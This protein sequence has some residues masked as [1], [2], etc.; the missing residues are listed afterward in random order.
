MTSRVYGIALASHKRRGVLDRPPARTM[1]AECG[2]PPL[3]HAVRQAAAFSRHD[4]VAGGTTRPLRFRMHSRNEFLR[5]FAPSRF[6]IE[7]GRCGSQAA[8]RLPGTTASAEHDLASAFDV[9]LVI[10]MSAGG[11]RSRFLRS[12]SRLRDAVLATLRLCGRK[13]SVPRDLAEPAT[14]GKAEPF[15]KVNTT[16]R[17]ECRQDAGRK[18]TGSSS[19]ARLS[20]DKSI[21][22]EPV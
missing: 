7:T 12:Q 20:P 19:S 6:S 5:V 18:S 13:R 21:R 11:G 9:V 17:G 3:P 14:F 15:P 1:T 22:A 10:E 4:L 16:S 8:I 2:A